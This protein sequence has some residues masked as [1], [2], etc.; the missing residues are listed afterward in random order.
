MKRIKKLS[1]FMLVTLLLI[2]STVL[3]ASAEVVSQDASAFTSYTYDVWGN[4]VTCPDPYVFRKSISGVDLGIGEMKKLNDVY[5]GEDGYL[6]MAVGGVTANENYL[7]KLDSQLNL[8][9]CMYGYTDDSATAS[10]KTGDWKLSLKEGST[11]G[12]AM[13]QYSFA[14]DAK[15]EHWLLSYDFTITDGMACPSISYNAYHPYSS[16]AFLNSSLEVNLATQVARV[17]GVQTKKA[18]INGTTMTVLPA[19]TYKGV[20][21]LDSL[22]PAS[23]TAQ[24]EWWRMGMAGENTQVTIREF[25]FVSGVAADHVVD[26]QELEDISST[27]DDTTIDTTPTEGDDS[28]EDTENT[29]TVADDASAE[30]NGAEDVADAA[31]DADTATDAAE[32]ASAETDNDSSQSGNANSGSLSLQ[33]AKP[34]TSTATGTKTVVADMVQKWTKNTVQFRNPMGVFVDEDGTIYLADANLRQIIKMDGDGNA[35]MIIDPPTPENSKGVITADVSGRY[36]PSKLV[37]DPTGRIHVVAQNVNQ[38]IMEFSADGV[39]QGYL[40]AAKVNYSTLELFWRQLSTEAMIDRMDQ[41]VPIEYNNI[42]LDEEGF[43]YATMA[44]QDVEVVKSEIASGNGTEQGALVRRLNLL[45]KDILRRNGYGPPVGDLAITTTSDASYTGISQIM[46][47]SCGEDNSY[48]LLDNN[49]NHIFTY[50]SE[51][52]LLYAFGGPDVTAGGLRT[53]TS[54]AQ[55]EDYLYVMDTGT[56]MVVMYEK[57]EFSKNIAAAIKCENEGR[58]NEAGTYWE[59]VL[60]QNANYDLA[61][62][63]L[64]KIAFQNGDYETAMSYFEKSYDPSWYSKAYKQ[65]RKAIIAEYFGVAAIVLIVIIVGFAVWDG[66]KKRKAR[67]EAERL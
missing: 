34:D 39:F 16:D 60:A 29:E 15:V 44:A 57:T 51:G 1:A 55:Y 52:Y 37:V 19:G 9:E 38:G 56:R 10:G 8:I 28:S 49:R 6:Y 27:E 53:P 40:A 3:P 58:I 65:Y 35:L 18:T 46:D 2:G 14:K 12:S 20:L 41:F 47:V 66:L 54:F 4:T 32:D 48:M 24:Y 7:L 36:R 22:I 67:K 50:D 26:V 43:L 64:G 33:P 25:A 31:E 11:S 21:N 61:Y 42:D 30:D 5:T 23:F 17:A 62:I 59:K 45:G 13:A 63:G